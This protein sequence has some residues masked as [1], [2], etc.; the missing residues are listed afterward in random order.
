MSPTSGSDAKDT[1]IMVHQCQ[2]DAKGT[3]DTSAKKML[4]THGTPTP[5]G[6]RRVDHKETPLKS[7][8]MEK[9]Q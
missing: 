2:N 9:Y 6:Y 8:C 7:N 5:K 1:W 3:W 4:K